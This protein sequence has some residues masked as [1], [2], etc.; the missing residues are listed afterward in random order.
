MFI[1]PVSMYRLCVF[2]K[3]PN[4]IGIINSFATGEMFRNVSNKR[5]KGKSLS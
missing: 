2:G 5:Y 4:V 3:I 1:P